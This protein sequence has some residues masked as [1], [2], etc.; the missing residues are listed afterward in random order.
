MVR[1]FI[2]DIKAD[3]DAQIVPNGSGLITA[4]IVRPIMID[5][6]DSTTEDQAKLRRDAP[7]LAVP[8]TTSY[9]TPIEFDYEEGGDG[10]FLIVNR[11]AGTL[12]S[13]ATPGFS[14]GFVL[15]VTLIGTANVRYDMT[16]LVG[17]VE[18][19]F[20]ASGTGEGLNDPITL[21]LTGTSLSTPASGVLQLGLKTDNADDVDIQSAAMKLDILPT[22]NP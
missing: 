8:L 5:T 1:R 13:S 6:L 4:D 16:A 11:V 17:G 19:G 3:V 21:N 22:N 18:T 15:E 14:Y 7:Q 9:T 10:N 20:V 2:D 12:T